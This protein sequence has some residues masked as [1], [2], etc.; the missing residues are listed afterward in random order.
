MALAAA[1]RHHRWLVAAVAELLPSESVPA[2][3]FC[4]NMSAI[5]FAHNQKI[6]DRTKHIDIAYHSTRELV[7]SGELTLMHIPGTDNLADI[8]TKGL[9]RPVLSQLCA[10]ITNVKDSAN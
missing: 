3:L 5:D 4:D 9:P 6:N 8:C 2:A 1:N 10:L 7:E